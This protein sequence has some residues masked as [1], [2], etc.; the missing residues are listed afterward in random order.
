[1]GTYFEW[2]LLEVSPKSET[3]I[4]VEKTGDGDQKVIGIAGI[5]QT[6]GPSGL[7]KDFWSW[8]S[9]SSPKKFGTEHSLS[10]SQLRVEIALGV[11]PVS[12]PKN[13]KMNSKEK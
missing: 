13:P 7:E 5:T 12:L 2:I 8:E 4:Y 11:L 10:V 6:S 9:F 3:H 1:M